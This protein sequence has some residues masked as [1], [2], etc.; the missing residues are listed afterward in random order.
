MLT[1]IVTIPH[2]RGLFTANREHHI[3]HNWDIMQISMDCGKLSSNRHIYITAS[4]SIIQET[5]GKRRGKI[6]KGRIP[7][8]LLF[9]LETILKTNL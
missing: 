5:S 6:G 9:L 4:A 1:S 3:N 8:S 7:G 2:V